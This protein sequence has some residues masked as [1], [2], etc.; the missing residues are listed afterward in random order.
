MKMRSHRTLKLNA[1]ITDQYET[2]SLKFGLIS[3]K[4]TITQTQKLT[5]SANPNRYS[6]CIHAKFQGTERETEILQLNNYIYP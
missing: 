4:R 6:N 3:Q 1:K 2:S 5:V